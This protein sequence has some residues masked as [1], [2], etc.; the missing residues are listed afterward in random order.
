MNPAAS[1]RRSKEK[2]PELYCPL[3]L[4]RTGGGYCPRHRPLEGPRAYWILKQGGQFVS[5]I[6]GAFE[7]TT[8]PSEAYKFE[9]R[10]NAESWARSIGCEVAIFEKETLCNL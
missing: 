1:A 5:Q 3:C 8:N 7:F 2:H 6:L 4:W 9:S 10:A